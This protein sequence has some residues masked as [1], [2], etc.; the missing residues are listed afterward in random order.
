MWPARPV[1]SSLPLNQ[2]HR[3]WKF[4]IRITVERLYLVYAVSWPWVVH[5][6]LYA[7]RPTSVSILDEA[8]QWSTPHKVRVVY[9]HLNEP[10]SGTRTHQRSEKS[11]MRMG[12]GDIS[13]TVERR[14]PCAPYGSVDLE[15]FEV[16]LYY[17]E[18]K[19]MTS[20]ISP[21]FSERFSWR[22]RILMTTP[23]GR[24]WF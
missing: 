20:D 4:D 3:A 5:S 11:T 8:Y 12:M 2:V 7:E 19:S 16:A 1:L 24:D 6:A 14:R 9:L 10:V 15:P 22:G 17:L 18:R 23:A 13:D 21:S